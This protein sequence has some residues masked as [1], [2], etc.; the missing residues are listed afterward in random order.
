M[1]KAWEREKRKRKTEL[2]I[3]EIIWFYKKLSIS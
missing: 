2:H 1:E 3:I